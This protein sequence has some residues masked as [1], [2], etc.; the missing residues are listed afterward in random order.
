MVSTTVLDPRHLYVM[1]RKLYIDNSQFLWYKHRQKC[2][3]TSLAFTTVPALH[4]LPIITQSW[5]YVNSV[6]W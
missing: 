5:F 1:D 2:T 3:Q 4:V 6:L